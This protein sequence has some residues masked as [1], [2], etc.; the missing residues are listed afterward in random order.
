MFLCKIKLVVDGYSIDSLIFFL[1]P[2]V[3][4][5]RLNQQDIHLFGIQSLGLDFYLRFD[6]DSGQSA[7]EE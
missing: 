2:E 5:G 4:V 6:F 3:L 1:S 7:H